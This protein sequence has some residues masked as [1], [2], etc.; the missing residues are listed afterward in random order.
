[1]SHSRTKRHDPKTVRTD[2][3]AEQL[4]LAKQRRD[5]QTLRDRYEADDRRPDECRDHHTEPRYRP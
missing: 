1:M 5:D 3:K 4:R 2:R